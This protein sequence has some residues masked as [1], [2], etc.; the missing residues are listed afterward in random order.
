MLKLRSN[1]KLKDTRTGSYTF[2]DPKTDKEYQIIEGT[3]DFRYFIRHEDYHGAITGDP[4]ECVDAHGV[5]RTDP[6]VEA[7]YIG[8]ANE[9]FVCYGEDILPGHP[10][11]VAVHYTLS[12]AAK[13]VR[14]HFEATKG[15]KPIS[16]VVTLQ[17]PTP[18]STVKHRRMLLDK[19]AVAVK[20]GAPVKHRGP[21]KNPTK[22]MLYPRPR[23]TIIGNLVTMPIV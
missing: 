6:K 2:V 14:D 5:K 20:N 9:A 10:E 18:G 1:P 8:A 4:S 15:K 22:K 21:N 23:P 11:A 7:V 16:Q 19:R 17:V 3:E 12:A 13:H